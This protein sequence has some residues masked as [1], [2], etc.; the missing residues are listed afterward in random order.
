MASYY[1]IN[2]L[3]TFICQISRSVYREQHMKPKL[4]KYF[5]LEEHTVFLQ[6]SSITLIDKTDGSDPASREEC[7]GAVLKTMAP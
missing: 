6:G 2:A 7:W 4:F 1:V 5:H 3:R